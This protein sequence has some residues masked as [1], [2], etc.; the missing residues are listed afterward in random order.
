MY[1]SKSAWGFSSCRLLTDK[2]PSYGLNFG[3]RLESVFRGLGQGSYS[4][5]RGVGALW[6]L[7]WGVQISSYRKFLEHSI[8]ISVGGSSWTLAC[9][10]VALWSNMA[11]L[12]CFPWFKVSLIYPLVDNISE[13]RVTVRDKLCCYIS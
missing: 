5:V 10:P 13:S 3:I 9:F 1:N 6:K 2:V 7:P 12:I 8:V 4:P 11:I